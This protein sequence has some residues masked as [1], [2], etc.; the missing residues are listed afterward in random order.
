MLTHSSQSETEVDQ[1]SNH[2]MFM[3]IEQVWCI[4][5]KEGTLRK[6][7]L[8]LQQLFDVVSTGTG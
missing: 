8:L 3:V 2:Q 5:S 1:N 7:E 6:L 4:I